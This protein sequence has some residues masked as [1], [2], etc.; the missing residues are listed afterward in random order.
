VPTLP[1]FRV[2]AAFPAEISAAR[3]VREVSAVSGAPKFQAFQAQEERAAALAL[4]Q[5]ARVAALGVAAP[6][7][8][9]VVAAVG[10][11]DQARERR[12]HSSR[13]GAWRAWRGSGP[14]ASGSA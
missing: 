2:M 12:R 3:V 8:A 5:P 4:G 6:T 7:E 11:P 14:I 9:V 1:V 10:G 13:C